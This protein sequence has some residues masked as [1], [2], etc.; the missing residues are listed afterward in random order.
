MARKSIATKDNTITSQGTEPLSRE[1]ARPIFGENVLAIDYNF[2]E[3]GILDDDIT[4]SRA[5]NATYVGSDGYIKTAG[6][7]V[8]RFSYDKDGNSKGLLIEEE[9]TNLIPYSEN[10]AHADWVKTNTTIATSGETDPSGGTG[11]YKYNEAN[12]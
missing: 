5:S 7:N 2:A 6:N 10:F 12:S 9:R 4:F 11:A 8:A 3:K 1:V